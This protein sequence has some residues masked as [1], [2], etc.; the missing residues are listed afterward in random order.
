MCRRGVISFCFVRIRG[1]IDMKIE[2]LKMIYNKLGDEL[3]KE[4]FRNRLL[5]SITNEKKW[6]IDIIKTTKEGKKFFGENGVLK[7]CFLTGECVIWGSGYWGESLYNFSSN[8][9]WK[10]I[11]DNKPKSDKMGDILIISG[12]KFLKEY[13]NEYIFISTRLYY[14]EIHEQLIKAGISEE[15]I[16]NV[17]K[18]LDILMSKQYF[19][20]EYLPQTA[21]NE[22][23]FVDVGCYD[24]MSSV[25]FSEWS[26]KKSKIYAFETNEKIHEECKRNFQK[27]NL[28]YVLIP[29]GAWSEETTLKFESDMGTRSYISERGKIVINV[30]TIDKVMQDVEVT[31]IKMDI[32]GAELQALIGAEN[33]IKRNKPKLAISIYHKPEDIWELPEIILKYNPQYKLYLRHYNLNDCDTVLYAI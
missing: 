9:N 33:I 12:E 14:S 6:I 17:G 3:S 2:L 25:Y 1:S 15:R 8:Y 7:K 4:I 28:E 32:E 22:E 30:T 18:I 24:G 10:Y 21:N 11:V 23:I 19:D 31:F 13:Q 26:K 29:K 27:N 20:L 16:I 5:Y